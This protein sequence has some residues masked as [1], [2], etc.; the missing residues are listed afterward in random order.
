M[1]NDTIGLGVAFLAGMVS[2][3][4]PDALL[5]AVILASYISGIA[6]E[7]MDDKYSLRVRKWIFK[8]PPSFHAFSFLCGFFFVF[9]LLGV[10]VAAFGQILLSLQKYFLMLGGGVIVLAG[11]LISGF[12]PVHYF[13]KHFFYKSTGILA[14]FIIGASFGFGGSPFV[15]PKLGTI[16]L[17]TGSGESFWQGM[18]LL[19]AFCLGFSIPLTFFSFL[20]FKGIRSFQDK[21]DAKRW[22]QRGLGI[23]LILVGSVA[24]VGGLA[25]FSIWLTG[26]FDPWIQWLMKIG[27]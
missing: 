1:M 9:I 21:P 17:L 25:D 12:M 16:L 3:L 22:V 6:F 26:V 15:G 7:H 8:I 2:F 13:R 19:L 14:S 23:V 27:M 5:L 10:S 24:L 4:S 20:L 18:D 11:L